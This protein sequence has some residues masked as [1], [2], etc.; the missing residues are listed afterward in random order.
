MSQINAVALETLVRTAMASGAACFM[1]K[2]RLGAVDPYEA[3]TDAFGDF[4]AQFI[5]TRTDLV[6]ALTRTE[7]GVES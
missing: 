3:L 2:A 1:D 4:P 5:A 7:G 6:D